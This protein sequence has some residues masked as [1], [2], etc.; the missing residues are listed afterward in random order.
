MKF[1]ISLVTILS[2]FMLFCLQVY[3]GYYKGY[4]W[5]GSLVRSRRVLH[6]EAS[7]PEKLECTTLPAHENKCSPSWKLL[8]IFNVWKILARTF[9]F[10]CWCCYL[11]LL[12]FLDSFW[13]GLICFMNLQEEWTFDFVDFLYRKF[14]YFTDFCSLEFL[15]VLFSYLCFFQSDFSTSAR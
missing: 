1:I 14:T 2:L 12:L 4:R 9:L 15:W 13:Q 6:R 8:Y 11:C 3:K 5:R 7:V 10:C